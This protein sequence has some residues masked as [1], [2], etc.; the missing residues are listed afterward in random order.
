MNALQDILIQALA[1]PHCAISWHRLYRH[2]KRSEDQS[3]REAVLQQVIAS[4]LSDPKAEIL[5]L[6]FLSDLT[7]NRSFEEVA[8][9]KVLELSP[10]SPDRLATFMCHIWSCA[11]RDQ[12]GWADFISVLNN[13]RMHELASVLAREASALL[14]AKLTIRAPNSIGR[15]AIVAPHL[16]GPYHPPSVMV[17]SQCDILAKEGRDVQVFSCQEMSPPDMSQ[18][19]GST[20]TVRLPTPDVAYWKAVLPAETQLVLSGT[21]VSLKYRWGDM[22]SRIAEF[23]PD[24]ILM[25]GLYSPLAAALYARRP[26][27]GLNVHAL[28]PIAPLDVWLAPDEAAR[29]PT[30]A[31]WGG[32]FGAPRHYYHP[33]RIGR[34]QGP[35]TVSRSELGL[36][37]NAVV[38]VTV[39]ARLETEISGTWAA[40]MLEFLTRTPET[41]WLLVGGEGKLPKALE[42]APQDRVKVCGRHNDIRGLLQISD[43]Y[44]NPPRMGGGFSVAEAMA[45]GLP[46]LSFAGSDGGD[47]VGEMALNN[48]N[49]YMDRL[50]DL[51][52]RPGLRSDVGQIMHSRF[53]RRFDVTGSGPSLLSAF[54]L[55]A[56]IAQKRFI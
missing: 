42:Q 46:V 45:E 50:S 9:K 44:V 27:V 33:Y 18:F 35:E 52:Q 23:D 12:P 37:D 4:S 1:E 55:A 48:L 51:S 38:L 41:I 40:R 14:P 28:P 7:G 31:E 11:L 36:A 53:T 10:T 39:G 17:S 5:R 30:G 43:I 34:A 22:L 29:Y 15:I 2:W 24:A 26:V 13:A 19:R 3:Q 6:T 32:V 21:E 47:K 56:K 49:A 8:A 54:D 20:L 16:G 25:V